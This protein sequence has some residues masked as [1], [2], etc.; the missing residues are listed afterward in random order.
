MITASRLVLLAFAALASGCGMMDRAVFGGS[1]AAPAEFKST[2]LQQPQSQGDSLAN[3][4]DPKVFLRSAAQISQDAQ[5]YKAAAAH[6]AGT[7]A[8]DPSDKEAAANLARNLRYIG[9]LEDA[10]RVVLQGLRDHK[11]M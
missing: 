5:A 8:A 9:R 2:A 1:A 10:E 7:Y 6:W 11:A 4:D 3:I